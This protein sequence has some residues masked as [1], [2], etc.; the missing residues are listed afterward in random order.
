MDLFSNKRLLKDLK[1]INFGPVEELKYRL[2]LK[3]APVV[4]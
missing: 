4:K 3:I 1:S 2:F